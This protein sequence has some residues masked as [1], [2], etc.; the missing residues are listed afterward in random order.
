MPYSALILTVRSYSDK[1][2]HWRK[3]SG[4]SNLAAVSLEWGNL[5]ASLYLQ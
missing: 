5:T 2:A 1:C 4:S 3:H